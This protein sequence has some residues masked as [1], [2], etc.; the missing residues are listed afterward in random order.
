MINHPE[1][2]LNHKQK[3]MELRLLKGHYYLYEVHSKWDPEKKRSKKITGK[4]LGK[5]TEQD[6]FI[7][8]DKD[9]LRKKEVSISKVTVKELG[10]TVLIDEV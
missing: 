10:V 2:A 3:G 6:E 4:L 8:S 9:R 5:I 7:I 1:W